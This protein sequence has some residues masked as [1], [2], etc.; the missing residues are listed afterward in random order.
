MTFVMSNKDPYS[1][2]VSGV[3]FLYMDMGRVQCPAMPAKEINTSIRNT[4][5]A[6]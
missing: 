6:V 2:P 5:E 1:Q 4:E 3:R